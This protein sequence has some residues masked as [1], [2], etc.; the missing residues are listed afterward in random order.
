MVKCRGLLLGKWETWVESLAP[1]VHYLLVHLR[2]LKDLQMG[3]YKI[4]QSGPER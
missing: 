1:H 4:N 3:S 2:S